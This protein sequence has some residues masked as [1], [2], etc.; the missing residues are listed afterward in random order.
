MEPP[1]VGRRDSSRLIAAT[2]PKDAIRS[3]DDITNFLESLT[4]IQV[5]ILVTQIF[6]KS[7]K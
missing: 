1:T 3:S 6:L 7:T 5:R 2:Y 4:G